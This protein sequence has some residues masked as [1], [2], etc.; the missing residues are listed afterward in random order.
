MP[1]LSFLGGETESIDL[2]GLFDDAVERGGKRGHGRRRVA[3]ALSTLGYGETRRM[4]GDGGGVALDRREVIDSCRLLGKRDAARCARPWDRP[5]RALRWWSPACPPA[6]KTA[7]GREKSPMCARY[8]AWLRRIVHLLRDL[9]VVIA[10]V[11][12]DERDYGVLHVERAIVACAPFFVL[13]I[14]DADR[15]VV[16]AD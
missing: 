11:R 7:V 1:G 6:G 15:E 10:V 5:G 12:G 14:E 2:A 16:V 4:L 13:V 3:A 8:Q 9:D